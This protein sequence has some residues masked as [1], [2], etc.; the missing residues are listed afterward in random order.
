MDKVLNFQVQPTF[1]EDHYLANTCNTTTHKRFNL[2]K[3]C[4]GRPLNRLKVN[5]RQAKECEK[6]GKVIVQKC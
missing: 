5:L 4:H 2:N 1:K 3:A 6:L